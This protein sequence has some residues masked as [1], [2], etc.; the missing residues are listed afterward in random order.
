MC[1]APSEKSAISMDSDRKFELAMER[2]V[3]NVLTIHDEVERRKWQKQRAINLVQ[4]VNEGKVVKDTV[5]TSRL[6]PKKE[7]KSLT[8]AKKVKLFSVK[9]HT[10]L[11]TTTSSATLNNNQ[12]PASQST[13]LSTASSTLSQTS[14]GLVPASFEVY[15]GGPNRLRVS[16]KKYLTTSP[17]QSSGLLLNEPRA[18]QL[19]ISASSPSISHVTDIAEARRSAKIANILKEFKQS[20]TSPSSF[21]PR[22]YKSNDSSPK[23]L[24]EDATHIN[25]SLLLNSITDF[26]SGTIDAPS[27]FYGG[28]STTE[29][30]TGYLRK[31]FSRY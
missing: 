23:L 13:V 30:S 16:P 12:F 11:N 6:I 28:N 3:G 7:I 5:Y 26:K 31:Y 27:S 4:K 19:S 29:S 14:S 17:S 22:D 24:V 2:E 20:K 9:E 25:N 21:S 15:T 10:F 8:S 18:R 1:Q